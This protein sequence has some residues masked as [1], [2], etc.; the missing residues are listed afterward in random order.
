MSKLRP[1]TIEIENF[2]GIK[3]CNLSF[4][5]GVF[6]I[7][8]QNGA[9]KSSLLEAI[10]FAL[11]GTGVRYGKKSPSEYI[12]SRSSSC[13]IKFS[14][15]R[16]GKK[17]EVIRRIK[18]SGGSEAS[19]SE[20]NA[21]VTTHRTL[22]DKEL[23][24]IMDISYDSFITTFFLPQ[25]RAAHLLTARRSEIN[26][27]VFDVISP[28]KT[29]KAM[30][31]KIS[32]IVRKLESEHEKYQARLADFRGRLEK[33]SSQNPHKQ[34][35]ELTNAIQNLSGKI[36]IKQKELK[37]IEKEKDL[38]NEI[39][40]IEKTLENLEKKKHR[41]LEEAEEEKKISLAKSLGAEY[42]IFLT[43]KKQM[44]SLKDDAKVLEKQI[45]S[46]EYE[47]KKVNTQLEQLFTKQQD[48]DKRISQSTSELEKLQKIDI[49]SNE[50][51]KKLNELKAVKLRISKDI[52][53]LQNSLNKTQDLI[54]EKQRLLF[55]KQKQFFEQESEF[56]Q[57]KQKAIIHMAQEIAQTLQDGDICPVCGNSY[58]K[59]EFSTTVEE[60]IEKYEYLKKAIEMLSK[61]IDQIQ[62]EL[63]NLLEE[64][65][66]L[67]RKLLETQDDLSLHEEE[68]STVSKK[69]L[70]I[71]YSDDLKSKIH[72]LSKQIQ[73]AM[74]NKITVQSEIS[75]LKERSDQI[76][77]RISELKERLK[78]NSE[79]QEKTAKELRSNKEKFF[80][81]L[82]EINFTL[83]Q[84]E[85]YFKKQLP[86][87]S[88]VQVLQ[89][90]ESEIVYN[91]EKLTQLRNLTKISAQQCES[92]FAE[93]NNTVELLKKQRD[94]FIRQKAVMEHLIKELEEIRREKENLERI[95]NQ[96]HKEYQIAQSVKSTFSAREFQSYI[97]KIVLENILIK[98][99]DILDIL[100]DGRFRLSID[101]NGF[102]VIDDGIKRN[103]DGLSGGEKTLVSL[104]LAMSIAEIAAGQMEAFFIDE[105]FSA[106]DEDNKAKVAQTLKQME[107]LN[108]VIGFVTHDPQFAE[109]FDKKLVVEKGGVV[110]W[111]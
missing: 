17:Y 2:L 87:H 23:R 20:N 45:N 90:I 78:K 62:F 10:V 57:I 100:T 109:F 7:I 61:E 4:K 72:N 102:A 24:K 22:V 68:I 83:E 98:V 89:K 74:N 54:E 51:L 39:N 60:K 58:K 92:L 70:Q 35:S 91:K 11:Y 31:E 48:I 56:N 52:D 110:K 105:G 104:S 97:A 46:L 50:L 106:L 21:V 111:I 6:L 95:F 80:E 43:S 38:W 12:R 63:K 71:G 75:Q 108:R 94:N 8:G 66:N 36:D 84:F 73:N 85:S 32:E 44:E 55:Q 88:A 107:K 40:Q 13:Q 81:K 59:S 69:L 86:T 5:D 25:G 67:T 3:K 33:L 16:N 42:Q 53:D 29:I 76:N 15:L 65:E 14:F 19:L 49:E 18:A 99:N 64:K 93:L 47:F 77:K 82:G 103:A 1:L 9:G 26:D 28:K 41:V 101:E 30:Q 34:I 27:I 37:Q 96:I 79:Q